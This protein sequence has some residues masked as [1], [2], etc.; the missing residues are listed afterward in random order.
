MSLSRPALRLFCVLMEAG[1]LLAAGW[2]M[3]HGAFQL[4]TLLAVYAIYFSIEG[5]GIK[6]MGVLER[7]GEREKR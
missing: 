2:Q 3:L 4:A 5:W 1:L 6:L 7:G